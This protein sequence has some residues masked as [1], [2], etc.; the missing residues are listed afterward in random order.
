M[1]RTLLVANK[2]GQGIAVV[3]TN[4]PTFVLNI[5]K[6]QIVDISREPKAKRKEIEDNPENFDKHLKKIKK[7]KPSK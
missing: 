2:D 7:E 1:K 6:E 5:P 3:G 4:D